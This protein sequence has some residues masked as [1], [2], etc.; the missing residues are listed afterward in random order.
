MSDHT[1]RIEA[2]VERVRERC[3]S[4][5]P[6][7]DPPDEEAAIEQLREGA[8]EAVAIYIEARTGDFEQIDPEEF[9][10][11]EEALNDSLAL[12]AAC[13][14]ADVA[15]DVS[16]REAAELVVESHSIREAAVLLTGVP[17]REAGES[18]SGRE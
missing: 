4:F 9:E 14:G 17:E 7:E 18:W 1:D 16:I 2:L 12:Y 3:E 10:R 11:L 6:P 13:Y 8:G 15:P 5:D